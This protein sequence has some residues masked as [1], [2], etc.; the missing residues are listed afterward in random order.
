MDGAELHGPDNLED[1][2]K[3]IRAVEHC[4]ANF[5]IEPGNAL[6]PLV[7]AV[8]SNVTQRRESYVYGANY[9]S[10]IVRNRDYVE[11]E[12]RKSVKLALCKLGWHV[13]KEVFDGHVDPRKLRDMLLSKM[14]QIERVVGYGSYSFVSK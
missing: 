8:M 2:R 7:K 3:L 12:I 14:L 13:E 9:C 4:E 11:D 10:T 1:V 5:R 6:T